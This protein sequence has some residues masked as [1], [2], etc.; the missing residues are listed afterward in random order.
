MSFITT[1]ISTG[2]TFPVSC[3]VIVLCSLLGKH[4]QLRLFTMPRVLLTGGSG[5]IAVHVLEALLSQGH[6]VVTSVRSETKAQMLRDTFPNASKDNLD[7]VLVDDIA[8]SGAF[9]DAVKSDPPFEWVIHTASPFHYNVTDTR[10]DLLD[11]AIMGTTGVLKAVKENAPTVKR[12]V[13]HAAVMAEPRS[14]LPME[15][16]SSRALSPLF[17]LQRSAI[18]PA[19]RTAKRTG[20]PLQ[21]RRRSRTHR[22]HIAHQRRLPRGR[23]GI[24]LRGRSQVSH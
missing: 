14:G 7:F 17:S 1:N 19:T 8:R 13:C 15:R 5:F 16:R 21:K 24:L 2:Q 6:S 4:S 10:K 20:T 9:D 12:V 11:P 22:T 23:R 18:D 3:I